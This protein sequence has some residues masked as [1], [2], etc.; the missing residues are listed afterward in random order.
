MESVKKIVFIVLAVILAVLNIILLVDILRPASDKNGNKVLLTNNGECV[1]RLRYNENLTMMWASIYLDEECNNLVNI[2]VQNAYKEKGCNVPG[3]DDSPGE[4]TELTNWYIFQQQEDKSFKEIEDF[5]TFYFVVENVVHKVE[6]TNVL[7]LTR[8]FGHTLPGL[9]STHCKKNGTTEIQSAEFTLTDQKSLLGQIDILNLSNNCKLYVKYKETWKQ[10]SNYVF[11]VVVEFYKSS[12][13]LVYGFD[14]EMYGENI[15]N[16]PPD[17]ETSV[18]GKP[19]VNGGFA[20][21][22]VG[23]GGGTSW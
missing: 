2:G 14:H 21:G 22:G 7:G 4:D 10:C 6:F 3:Q 15:S 5:N 8:S 17:I 13:M 11:N 19:G 12:S 20:G 16:L 23:G 18:T 1:F 9:F